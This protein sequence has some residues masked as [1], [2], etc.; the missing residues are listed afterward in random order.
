MN[1]LTGRS[2]FGVDA[3]MVRRQQLVVE[4]RRRDLH[5]PVA[6][7]QTPVTAKPKSTCQAILDFYGADHTRL[8]LAQ[9]TRQVRASCTITAPGC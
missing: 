4:L 6:Y 9:L 5:A 2:A 3:N 1:R 7:V 8:N